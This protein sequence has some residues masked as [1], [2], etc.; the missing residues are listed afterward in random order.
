M[1]AAG[2]TE[3]TPRIVV[4]DG[5]SATLELL[6]VVLTRHGY[7][8][9]TSRT[10]SDAITILDAIRPEIV[11]MEYIL[12]D[13]DGMVALRLLRDQYPDAAVVMLAA[14]GNEEIAVRLIKAGAS[15][16]LIKPFTK[17]GR[18]HV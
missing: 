6:S 17:I 9:A 12:P 18:A 13:M 2:S 16:Y 10:V 7:H 14:K 15:E 1:S 8:V 11:L 4:I 3:G 5:D